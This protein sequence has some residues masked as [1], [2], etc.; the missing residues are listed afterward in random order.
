MKQIINTYIK[1]LDNN[2]VETKYIAEQ[3]NKRS[4]VYSYS[5]VVGKSKE[6]KGNQSL[7]ICRGGMQVILTKSRRVFCHLE[8]RFVKINNTKILPTELLI[9]NILEFGEN[10]FHNDAYI[11]CVLQKRHL[12]NRIFTKQYFSTKSCFEYFIIDDVVI[13]LFNHLAAH[14]FRFK[15]LLKKEFIDFLYHSSIIE[16]LIKRQCFETI[17]IKS[18]NSK[19]LIPK[20]KSFGLERSSGKGNTLE[21]SLYSC[22]G[23]AIER[24]QFY[25]NDC[26]ALNPRSFR[27]N[28]CEA[29]DHLLSEE[30]NQV[31]ESRLPLKKVFFE[32][33]QNY[34]NTKTL[35]SSPGVY[36]RHS[37]NGISRPTTN[38]WACGSTFE[39]A[40][41][42]ALLELNERDALLT[43]WYEREPGKAFKI[44]EK[45]VSFLQRLGWTLDFYY[46][47]NQFNIP[48]IMCLGSK[49][50]ECNKFNEGAILIGA[51]SKFT[52]KDAIQ[53]SIIDV[54]QTFSDLITSDFRTKSSKKQVVCTAPGPLKH[55]HFNLLPN[56]MQRMSFLSHCLN[57]DPMVQRNH[58]RNGKELLDGFAKDI[59]FKSYRNCS[60]AHVIRVYL[61]NF[62]QLVF[63]NDSLKFN[64][65][66]NYPN[67]SLPPFC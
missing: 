1:T 17:N 38:G 30:I 37:M 44:Q 15:R 60:G 12:F 21:K 8:K 59:F 42:S 10:L 28:I 13:Q 34:Q 29:S 19:Y 3:L 55:L 39:K 6:K 14:I 20:D 24:L 65:K 22:V 43:L 50:A 46:I 11:S 62:K 32:Q 31:I 47:I 41:V 61:R 63:G 66:Y 33:L 57:Y 35:I 36:I 5:L 52:L 49:I 48:T 53:C 26:E 25:S 18:V 23:E 40:I 2:S 67:D 16:L 27:K 56:S 51:A 7:Y 4:N 54:E 64:E 9:E 58:F 45:K